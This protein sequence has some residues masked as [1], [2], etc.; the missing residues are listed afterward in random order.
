MTET[1]TATNGDVRLAYEVRGEGRPVLLVQGLGYARWGWDP[2]VDL[3]AERFLV[4][5]FDNRGIGLSD[6]PPGPYTA[7]AMAEDAAAVLA[8]VGLER[9]HVIGASLGGIVAQQL[10][11]A[12]PE[13]LDRLVL[14][15]TTPGTRGHPMPQ[16]TVDLLLEMPRMPFEQGIRSAIQNA[17][18][19]GTVAAR[20]ELV[21]TILE[22][23]LAEP[24]DFGGWQAQ[25]AAAMTFDG[26]DRLREIRAPT[27]VVQGTEDNVVDPRNAEL[28]ADCIPNARL[29]WF[30]GTGHLFFWEEPERFAA[31]VD[32]FLSETR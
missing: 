14:A 29:E 5:Y 10:A 2:I 23:R 32:D 3:L 11:V 22:R 20:P 26:L 31:V 25:A 18:A 7:A 9:A 12:A 17:L 6:I 1:L 8:A 28:L 15:C 13:K 27:L 19:A 4:V 16:K 24:F 30:P 21:E